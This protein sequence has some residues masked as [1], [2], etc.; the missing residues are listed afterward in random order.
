MVVRTMVRV[1]LR[2]HLALGVML[3]VHCAAS[4]LVQMLIVFAVLTV[5]MLDVGNHVGVVVAIE[6]VHFSVSVIHD[7]HEAHGRHWLDYGQ[8]AVAL[9]VRGREGASPW[10]ERQ[11]CGPSSTCALR[12]SRRR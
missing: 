12:R 8:R 2:G 6:I 1:H 11:Y 5:G 4:A 7:Y 3:R 10:S 9:H